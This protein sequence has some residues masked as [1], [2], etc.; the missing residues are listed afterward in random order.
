M[1]LEWL[2]VTPSSDVLVGHSWQFF[3]ENNRSLPPH[4][5]IGCLETNSRLKSANNTEILINYL[6][7][8]FLGFVRNVVDM[9]EFRD[10]NDFHLLN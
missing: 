1:D 2:E 5:F 3:F 8:S 10:A 9:E 6:N 4:L 7:L